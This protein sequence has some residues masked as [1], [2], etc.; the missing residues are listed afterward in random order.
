MQTLDLNIYGIY[1]KID[2]ESGF[3]FDNL[4]KD[5]MF[6]LSNGDMETCK[7]IEMAL[8]KAAPPYGKVPPLEAHL[9]GRGFISYRDKGV[10]Y[11]D[12]AGKALMIYDFKKDNAAFYSED[13]NLLYEKTRLAI[14]SRTGELLDKKGIHRLHAVG[15]AKNGNA[16]VCL[17]PMEGGK[18]TLAINTLKKD[19]AVGLISEDI[20]LVD[21]SNY[22]YPFVL[23][24]GSRERELVSNIPSGCLTKI[25][26]SFY[27]EKYLVD[28]DYFRDRIAQKSRL[29]DILIGK[30][31]FQD[32]T[33]IRRISKARCIMPF[34][35]SGIFGLGL[36]QI[37]E[38]FLQ[39]GFLDTLNKIKIIFSRAVIFFII[40]LR[41]DTYEFR[42]GRDHD[43]SADELVKFMTNT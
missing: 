43:S 31:F 30:R 33:E 4:K 32:K 41:T 8:Y 24:M 13:E 10:H 3:A 15:F 19:S 5:F 12:Y 18:T 40:I 1:I 38:L 36:P 35:Q 2:S 20:C 7:K 34:I 14:L 29:R 16:S 39:G 9:Y 11:V 42:I 25:N 23:R 27:G 28:I 21:R 26:R 6:Y 17:L 37:V 22:V